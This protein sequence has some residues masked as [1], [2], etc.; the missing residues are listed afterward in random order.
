MSC[1]AARETAERRWSTAADDQKIGGDED[2]ERDQR[3]ADKRHLQA[4][5][6]IEIV[7]RGECLSHAE[8]AK[9][10]VNRIVP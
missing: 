3:R 9:E 7:L 4:L 5:E 10:V 6:S 1:K 8:R 2:E